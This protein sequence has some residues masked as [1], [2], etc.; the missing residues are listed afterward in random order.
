MQLQ[1]TS[2]RVRDNVE[3]TNCHFR[4]IR[5]A[6]ESFQPSASNWGL[7]IGIVGNGGSVQVH[8]VTIHHNSATRLDTFF[9]NTGVSA[10]DVLLDANTV[11]QCGGNCYGM[12]G[13]TN[14]HIT[15]SVFLRDAPATYFM[16]G[17]TDVIIGSISGNNS[18][19]N[20]DF[21][22]RG[23]YEAGPDGCAIDFETSAVGFAIRGNTIYRS[24]GGGIMVFGHDTTSQGFDIADNTFVYAG[25]VQPRDDRAGIAFMCPGGHKP[26]GNV[27]NNAFVTCAGVPAMYDAVKGCSSN[28]TKTNNSI[29]STPVVEQPQ[30]TFA[31][32][33][34]ASTATSVVIP[35]L[36]VTRTP[37]ATLR[38]TLD[39]S[40]PTAASPAVP[41]KGVPLTWPGPD[42]AMNVRAFHSAMRPSVTNG[43][44]VERSTYEP[45]GAQGF[46]R[47]RASLD[48]VTLSSTAATVRGW[49]VDTLLPGRGTSPVTVSVLVDAREVARAVANTRRP[50]LVPAGVAP[51]P[52][53]GFSIDLDSATVHALQAGH[54]VVDAFVVD[55]P[56]TLLQPFRIPRAPLCTCGGAVCPC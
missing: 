39:G 11:A 38:Y 48:N 40:R 55:S 54:H 8:N 36:A 32:P 16:Y 33:D 50:D 21:N 44:V 43:V 29:D 53:H 37:N 5:H 12:T 2:G 49:A 9:A 31:P 17:T 7:A 30:I 1:Y 28:V 20:C 56:L 15:N 26:S 51:D 6:Y 19:E 27:T 13:G 18:I 23:E 35:A 14:M 25:C 45:R 22:T 47:V 4:D 3:V 46:G 10:T 24:W 42:I 41:V 52:D 34:P